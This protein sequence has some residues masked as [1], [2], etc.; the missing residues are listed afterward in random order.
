MRLVIIGS[1][2]AS[3]AKTSLDMREQFFV[4]EYLTTF[5]CALEAQVHEDVL[6]DLVLLVE[7]VY[8]VAKSAFEFAMRDLF[9][10]YFREAGEA[11]F[12]TKLAAVAAFEHIV[13]D[14]HA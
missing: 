1:N 7:Y 13:F 6:E 10:G 5:T 4:W 9:A 8:F 2:V 12:A 11:F 3:V 14:H